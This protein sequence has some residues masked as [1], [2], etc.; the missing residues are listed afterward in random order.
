MQFEKYTVVIVTY[1]RKSL[2]AE[3]IDQVRKQTV[4][5]NNIIVVN[6]S[7][8][9]GT[10]D[11][12]QK[13]KADNLQVVHCTENVGGAGGFALGVKESLKDTSDCVLLIDDDAILS[14]DYMEQ[15]LTA[16]NQ[17]KKYSAFAGKVLVEGKV[18]IYHRKKLSKVGMFLKNCEEELYQKKVFECDIAS[19]CGMLVNKEIIK[20]IG[21]PQAEYFIWH[22][23]TEYSL[24]RKS[25]V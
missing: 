10:G 7:S 5:A 16:K 24:D 9:D 23:D 18:D 1:N 21:V 11:Y 25:V 8:T 15:L 13:L 20:K 22:D 4:R 14:L 2:L 6:N 17:N 12:L 19:F 3:C